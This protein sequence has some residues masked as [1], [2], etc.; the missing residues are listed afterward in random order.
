MNGK[1]VVVVDLDGTLANVEHRVHMLK[2]DRPDWDAFFKACIRDTPNDWC[3][4]LIEHFAGTYDVMIVSARSKVV[5]E[6]TREWLVNLF[7]DML[8]IE[9]VM[10]REAGDNTP[11]VTLKK[12]WL[13]RFGKSRILFVVDDRQRVVNMWREEGL[14]CLQCYAWKEVQRGEGTDL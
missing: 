1:N 6:E 4:R 5:E 8:G 13:D 12:A 11:D 14:T 7:P 9:L 3:V 2:G 10:L